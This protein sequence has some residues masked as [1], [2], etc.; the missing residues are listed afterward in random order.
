MWKEIIEKAWSFLKFIFDDPE[1]DQDWW[2]KFEN[3]VMTA[4]GTVEA[5]A[6]LQGSEG[7]DKRSKAIEFVLNASKAVGLNFKLPVWLQKMLIGL[8]IDA[9]VNFLNEKFG[10]DWLGKLP[11]LS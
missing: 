11:E 7:W 3:I 4:I 2:T 1:N 6:E 8:A 9:L 10:H 5:T